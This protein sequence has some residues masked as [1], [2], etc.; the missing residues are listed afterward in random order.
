VSREPMWL[1][2]PM[3]PGAWSRSARRV[4]TPSAKRQTWEDLQLLLKAMG[5]P[6]EKS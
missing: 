3:A 4:R 5:L 1:L 6:V 2:T